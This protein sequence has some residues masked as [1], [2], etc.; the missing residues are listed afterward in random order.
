MVAAE[1]VAAQRPVGVAVME[2]ALLAMQPGTAQTG[3]ALQALEAVA[4]RDWVP[5][6]S[7]TEGR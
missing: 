2:A 5:R 1:V 7:T 6:Y 3:A 4:E